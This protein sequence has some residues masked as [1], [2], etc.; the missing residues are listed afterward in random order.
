MSQ[1]CVWGGDGGGNGLAGLQG[2]IFRATARWLT[3]SAQ[4]R[5]HV[6]RVKNPLSLPKTR[7]TECE[8]TGGSDPKR[9]ARRLSVGGGGELCRFLPVR[10]S[11]DELCQPLRTRLGSVW[12]LKTEAA[13]THRTLLVALYR[14]Q[15]RLG[16]FDVQH[17]DSARVLLATI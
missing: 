9:R 13:F 10:G 12:N 14:L 11:R 15:C 6:Y 5:K 7:S 2:S 17:G 1:V 8:T 4:L 16:Q 3:H